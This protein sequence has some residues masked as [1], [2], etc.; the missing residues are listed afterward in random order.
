MAITK[1]N[2]RLKGVWGI[3][4]R[5]GKEAEK[6]RDDIPYKKW[7]NAIVVVNLLII[8]GIFVIKNFLPPEVPI[9]YGLPSGQE[10]LGG[11]YLLALPSIISLGVIFLN[12][13]LGVFIKD[14][15]LVKILTLTGIAST[16]FSL[17][18]TVKIIFL[19]GNF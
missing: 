5:I 6:I 16:F 3:G 13:L 12:I 18:T 9:F 15:F 10:Q 2:N 1:Q 4:S 19:V 11:V 17:V 7:V 14:E 8:A